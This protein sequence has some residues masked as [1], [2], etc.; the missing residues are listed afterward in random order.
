MVHPLRSRPLTG[1]MRAVVLEKP[2]EVSRVEELTLEEPRAGEVRVR[3]TASGVCH[4]DLHVRDGDWIR[5]GPIAL[6]HE[7]AGVVEALGPGVDPSLLGRKVALSWYYPCLHCRNCQ[8]GRQ[9][10]CTDTPALRHRTMDGTTR[11]RRAS[12][13]EVVSYLAIGTMAE[14]TVVPVAAAIPMPDGVAAEVAAL[15]GCCVSTGVGAVLKTADVPAGASVVVFGLGGVG[16]SVVMGAVVAGATTIVAVDR[17]PEKLQRATE[18]GATHTVLATD[19]DATLAAIRAA[20]GGGPD[21]AFEAIGVQAT[22]EQA[23]ACLPPGGTAVLVGLTP[24][25]ARASFEVF[26]FVDG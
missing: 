10:L 17:V 19:A 1:P 12:G 9:W 5:P 26:P 22:I 25:G 2:G 16:L 23:I 13:Q 4:S 20:T 15:I 14:R 24:F 3:I 21:Y 6:G 11:L 7:G 8:A 18:L